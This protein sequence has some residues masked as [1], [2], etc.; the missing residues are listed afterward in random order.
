MELKKKTLKG[1]T[2]L[3]QMIN[4]YKTT[5][6]DVEREMLSSRRWINWGRTY[7]PW[8]GL[9]K[10]TSWIWVYFFQLSW[11]RQWGCVNHI[12]CS[13]GSVHPELNTVQDES[14]PDRPKQRLSKGIKMFVNV[15][16]QSPWV[17]L[18]QKDPLAARQLKH[19]ILQ[20][21]ASQK[22]CMTKMVCS[23]IAQG[24]LSCCGKSGRMS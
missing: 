3:S 7:W 24:L 21:N 4:I 17:N 8:N 14:K 1:K 22:W 10:L 23:H 20:M 6:K 15:V 9:E 5:S 18:S 12:C 13:E 16:S 11:S 2:S 19:V